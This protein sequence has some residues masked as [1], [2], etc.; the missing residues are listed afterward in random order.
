MILFKEGIHQAIKELVN[1]SFEKADINDLISGNPKFQHL[2]YFD[3]GSIFK[4]D[5]NSLQM[6]Q[7]LSVM[8]NLQK[9]VN[10]IEAKMDKVEPADATL[11]NRLMKVGFCGLK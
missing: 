10:N 4:A 8:D 2:Q 11:S 1:I 6:G 5:M 3:P 7:V 9:S